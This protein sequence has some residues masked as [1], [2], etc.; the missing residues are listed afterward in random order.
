MHASR[1]VVGRQHF[2]LGAFWSVPREQETRQLQRSCTRGV[3]S[4]LWRN[5]FIDE[6]IAGLCDEPRPGVPRQIGDEMIEQ[7]V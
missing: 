1:E 3:Y 4:W 7:V 6:G 5:R 2:A